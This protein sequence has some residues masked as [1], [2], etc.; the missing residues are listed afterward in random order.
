MCSSG[1]LPSE[2][3]SSLR[4]MKAAGDN[5]ALNNV[6]VFPAGRRRGLG[7]DRHGVWRKKILF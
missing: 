5:A 3:S 1:V 4:A 6:T 7:G 2:S